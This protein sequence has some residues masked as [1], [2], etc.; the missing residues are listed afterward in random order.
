ML[1]SAEVS[2]P[3]T[4]GAAKM[5]RAIRIRLMAIK[6]P[7]KLCASRRRSAASS[8]LYTG[9]NELTRAP[10]ASSSRIRLGTLIATLKASVSVVS[11]RLMTCW[12]TMP[13][14]REPSVPAMTIRVLARSDLFGNGSRCGSGRGWTLGR[15]MGI[16]G[17]GRHSHAATVLCPPAGPG[18]LRL[19]FAVLSS[20]PRPRAASFDK[21]GGRCYT[22][23]R[24]D[25]GRKTV[26][27]GL[28]AQRS[29]QSA[30][31]RLVAGSNPAGPTN[32][33]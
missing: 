12:R 2:S 31:N 28:L 5:P 30:H 11:N 22:S 24:L 14:S 18:V 29:E 27:S 16:G 15:R 20:V 25:A 4:Q 23:S 33:W 19:L 13:D 6:R 1:A 32:I 7:L 10:S 21:P 8:V 9:M 17:S 26:H 3:T